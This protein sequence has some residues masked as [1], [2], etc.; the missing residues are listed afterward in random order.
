MGISGYP[1]TNEGAGGENYCTVAYVVE[2]DKENG[3]IYTGSDDGLVYITKNGGKEW[4]NIT[5][6]D[7]GEALINAIEVSPHDPAVV[8]LAATKYKFNDFTPFIYKSND[9]GKTWTKIVNG[10][11]YGAFTKVVREDDQRK[12]LLYAG[13]ETGLYISYDDG[14]NWKNMQLNLPITPITDLRVHQGNLIAATQGRAFWLLDDLQPIRSFN[15]N[16]IANNNLIPVVNSYRVSGYS[17][18]DANSLGSSPYPNTTSANPSTGAVVYYHLNDQA[19]SIKSLKLLVKNASG[20]IIRSFSNKAPEKKTSNNSIQNEPT[21]TVKKGLNRFVWDLRRMDM[22]TIDN[23]YIEGNYNGGKIAPGKYSIVLE[24]DGKEQSVQFVL[25]SDPRIKSTAADYAKQD[26]L[27]QKVEKDVTDIHVAV[28]RMR[29]LSKQIQSLVNLVD[30]DRSKEE[31]VKKAKSVMQKMV[32]WEELLIQ[33]KSQS[34]DDVIN[35]VNKLSANYIFVHG[36]ANATIPYITE[37]HVARYNE[38]HQEW[39]KYQNEM[40]S[41]MK[42]DIASLNELVKTLKVDHVMLPE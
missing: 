2:S 20:E 6:K 34:Y 38:L 3:V 4:A 1:Y 22:P 16:Q 12:G 27:L 21:L 13:T 5:P 23:V 15:V 26:E 37:G 40:E 29:N 39:M 36:E 32:D 30:G 25:N 8:Y 9:Y 33:P 19:D 24:I 31:L 7:L 28:V 17:M 35:F 41:L 18:F 11:P 42:T 10:I 14:A